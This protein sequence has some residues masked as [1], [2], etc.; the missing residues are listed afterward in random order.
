MRTLTVSEIEEVGGGPAVVLTPWCINGLKWA[1]LA[2]GA[3]FFGQLGVRAADEAIDSVQNPP[4]SCPK[5][6]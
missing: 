5:S 4:P 3:G 2:V 1:A 6:K